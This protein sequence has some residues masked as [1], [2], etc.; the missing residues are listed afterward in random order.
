MTLGS[1]ETPDQSTKLVD[2]VPSK[3]DTCARGAPHAFSA[4]T[5]VFM[6]EQRMAAATERRWARH[7]TPLQTW[8]LGPSL[9]AGLRIETYCD[10]PRARAST[11]LG[12]LGPLMTAALSPS[13]RASPT[14]RSPRDRS[15]VPEPAVD[16]TAGVQARSGMAIMAQASAMTS[17]EADERTPASGRGP[18]LGRTTSPTA[19]GW[20]RSARS[21]SPECAAGLG[22]A[23]LRRRPGPQASRPS[24]PQCDGELLG[25]DAPT[26]VKLRSC[27]CRLLVGAT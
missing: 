19:R 23:R 27:R 10:G 22:M 20:R 1:P 6:G 7:D 16:V 4:A 13:F 2:A 17:W 3:T 21:S 26:D 14:C 8:P 24:R 12:N 5:E 9:A 25:V 11:A 18:G 15:A